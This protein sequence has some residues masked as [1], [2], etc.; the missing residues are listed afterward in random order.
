MIWF[1]IYICI[2]MSVRKGSEEFVMG[3]SDINLKQCVVELICSVLPQ[4]NHVTDILHEEW[5]I[6]LV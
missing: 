3:S 2:G 6:V 5:E 1:R 4:T